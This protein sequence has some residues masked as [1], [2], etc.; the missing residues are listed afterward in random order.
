M[1]LLADPLALFADG[2]AYARVLP[3]SA[4]GR[5]ATVVGA[6]TVG[7]FWAGAAAFWFDHPL[8]VPLRKRAGYRSGREL[9]LRY[10][11]ADRGRRRR[12]DRREDAA[13][14]AGFATY[15]LW[16]WL[17]WD[18]GRRRRPRAA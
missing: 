7:V 12:R 5:A 1:S 16:W 11:F 2:E 9:M 14:L 4:Q 13:A 6:F 17:G 8:V 3:E 18:H 15:P 10:P